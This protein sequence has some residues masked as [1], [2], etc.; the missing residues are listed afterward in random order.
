MGRNGQVMR[1]EY[2]CY[3]EGARRNSE[4][5]S[6]LQGLTREGCDAKLVVVRKREVFVVSKFVKGHNNELT[7]PRKV[8]LL[9]SHLQVSV[10]Q[11]ALTQQLSAAN[12]STYQQISIFELQVGGLENVEFLPQDLYND[13]RDMKN[14]VHGH[15]VNMLYEHFENEQQK[16]PG[17][18]FTFERD[19]KDRMTHCFRADATSRKSYQYFGDVVVFDTTYYTNKYFLIFAPILGVNHH[20][21]TPF[22]GCAFLSDEKT[23]SFVWFFNE[24]SKAMPGGPPKMI[25]TD[26]D[27][28]MTKANACDLPNMFHRYCIWH[29]ISK[30]SEKLG[31]LSYKEHYDE[32]KKCI[33]NSETPGE[34]DAR[35]ANIVGNSKLSNNKWL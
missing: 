24:W 3:K 25:I 5:T 19:D 16:N 10:A 29:I 23:D 31:A 22:I 14:V 28:A 6:R 2:A 15:D 32:L 7:T 30:F 21:K 13:K 8:H 33:W 35:W 20:R 12:V 17:F 26:Q 1:K 18:R 4:A 27:P 9:K 11:K 34:F